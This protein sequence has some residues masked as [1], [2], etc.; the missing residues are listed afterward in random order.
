VTD[1]RLVVDLLNKSAQIQTNGRALLIW[2]GVTRSTAEPTAH[3]AGWRRA[4]PWSLTSPPDGFWCPVR[5][6]EGIT[7]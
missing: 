7:P 6:C 5:R 3:A 1:V 4:G 2:S